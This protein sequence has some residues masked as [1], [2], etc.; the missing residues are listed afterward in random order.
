MN[1]IKHL[2]VLILVIVSFEVL[3]QNSPIPESK[4]QIQFLVGYN[5]TY[6]KD[7]NFSPLNYDAS[8]FG[9]GIQ[10]LRSTQR[11]NYFFANI[12]FSPSVLKAAISEFN[13]ADRYLANLE[14][15]FLV[16]LTK[17]KEKWNFLLGGQYHTYLSFLFY[18]DD[19]A[20]TFLGLHSL[21]LKAKFDYQ[22]SQK[23]RLSTNIALPIFGLLVRPPYTGWNKFL[24]DNE[25]RPLKILTT[26]DWTSFNDFFAFQWAISYQYQFNPKWSFIASNTFS[27][28]KTDQLDLNKNIDNLFAV[29]L[30]LQF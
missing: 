7:L 11:N 23:H 4:N 14:I 25:N 22:F 21:D 9:V 19:D 8:S 16:N 30:Q 12:D 3:A 27:Y 13:D 10:Y 1:H 5:Q 20:I 29:G 18:G 28:Y 17:S 6:F 24:G 2:I 26:G 15:G